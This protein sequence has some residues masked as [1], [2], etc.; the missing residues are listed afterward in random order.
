MPKLDELFARGD[1]FVAVGV[2][3]VIDHGGL[4]QVLRDRGYT[5]THVDG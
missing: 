5:V 1:V 4:V 3:H 2:L